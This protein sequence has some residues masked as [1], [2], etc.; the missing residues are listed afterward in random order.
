[1]AGNGDGQRDPDR[2]LVVL[3]LIAMG[4]IPDLDLRRRRRLA[5]HLWA[6]EKNLLG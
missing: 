6:E 2:T 3:T 1:M 5:Q 4:A